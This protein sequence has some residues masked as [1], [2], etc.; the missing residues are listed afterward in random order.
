[1]IWQSIEKVRKSKLYLD[2]E[3]EMLGTG[4]GDK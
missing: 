2:E 3:R 1:M 4:T